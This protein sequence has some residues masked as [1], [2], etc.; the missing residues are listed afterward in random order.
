MI[1]ILAGVALVCLAGCAPDLS[2]L[3]A[4]KNAL[5]LRATYVYGSVEIDRN[6]GCTKQ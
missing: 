4:D 3:A 1:R 2:A 6:H 5:C